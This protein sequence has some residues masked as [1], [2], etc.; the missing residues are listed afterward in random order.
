M[1]NRSQRRTP[2]RYSRVYDAHELPVLRAF[3]LELHVSVFFSEQRVI[4]TA[5]NVGAGMKTRAAL[6]ND[7]VAGN[8]FLA[9]VDLDA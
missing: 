2:T 9:A 6:A 4:T 8:D 5:P 3:F 1:R 7:D